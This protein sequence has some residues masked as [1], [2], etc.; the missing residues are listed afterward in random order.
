MFQNKRWPAILLALALITGCFAGCGGQGG[1][2]PGSATEAGQSAEST[3]ASPSAASGAE[4]VTL[5]V[6]RWGG[7]LPAPDEDVIKAEL[8]ERLGVNIE[9]VGYDD[10]SDYI[11]TV[12]TRVA[13]GAYPDLFW[14]NQE[15][16]RNYSQKGL[17]MDLTDVYQNELATVQG[18]LGDA[19]NLGVVNGKTYGIPVPI[20]FEYCLTF[21]RE[22]WLNTLGLDMPTNLEELYNVAV[23]FTNDDPDGNGKSDT[24]ALTGNNGLRA[25]SPIFGA[26]GVALPTNSG[27]LP[28]IYVKDGALVSTVTDPDIKEAIAEAKRFVDAGVIDPE[29]FG[30]TGSQPVQDKAFQGKVGMARIEWSLFA[31]DVHT[32]Q[33]KA[34]NPDASWIPVGTIGGGNGKE[35][36]GDWQI[37]TTV[38]MFAI[39][40]TLSQTPE[41]M[42]AL[43]K[44]L[45]YLSTEEG[46]RLVAYGMEGTLHEINAA[47]EVE[48]IN[49]D[50]WKE[51]DLQTYMY[52]YQFTGRG[53]ESVYLM[54]RNPTIRNV[55][56][57]AAAQPRIECLNGFV[58]FPEGFVASDAATFAEEEL[59]KFIYGRRP[60]EEYDDFV[61]TLKGLYNY[62]SYLDLAEETTRALGYIA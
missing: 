34:V 19:L 58:D 10:I 50:L 56:E 3:T 49:S 17:V 54:I 36:D 39:P 53:D 16:L 5:E 14:V 18:W 33:A 28:S 27:A 15:L 48:L 21:I 59:I 38:H 60:I 47:G 43:F 24:F 42:E 30:N 8:L 4:P 45:N 2:S 6:I 55:I 13:T 31:K 22:D 37:G 25:L 61:E 51:T 7:G 26:F 46:N 12:N 20:S 1:S 41:K 32:E 52:N 35:L 23:A 9:L 44:V 11:N 40:T 62:Q 57:F 29:L